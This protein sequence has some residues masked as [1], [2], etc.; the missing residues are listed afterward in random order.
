MPEQGRIRDASRRA[1]VSDEPIFRSGYERNGL[2]ICAIGVPMRNHE[3]A[4]VR[5]RDGNQW[6]R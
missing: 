2:A 1:T 6:V 4:L 5:S 3:S